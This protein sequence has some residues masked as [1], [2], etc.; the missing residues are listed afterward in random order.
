MD[1]KTEYFKCDCVY[2]RKGYILCAKCEEWMNYGDDKKKE[3]G[4]IKDKMR[5][6]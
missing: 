3:N 4:F 1:D 5:E 2:H 6:K